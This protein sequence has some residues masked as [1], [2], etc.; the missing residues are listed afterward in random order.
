LECRWGYSDGGLYVGAIAGLSSPGD[1]NL[2]VDGVAKVLGEIRQGSTDYGSYGIQTESR[3]YAADYG[4]FIGGVHVGGAEDPG[5]DNLFVDGSIRIGSDAYGAVVEKVM[6]INFAHGVANQI[7]YLE[8]EG[9]Y[10][11]LDVEI[12]SGYSNQAAW[13]SLT[14]R[15]YIAL[16]DT[17]ANYNNQ[18]WYID[19]GGDIDDNF[20]IGGASWT[21]SVWRIP[22]E[23]LNSNGNRCIVRIHA[24]AYSPT[25]A[26][27]IR[28]ASLSAVTTGT[29][30]Q[31]NA[32][33]HLGNDR[34]VTIGNGLVASLRNSKGMVIKNGNA[35]DEILTLENDDVNQPYTSLTDNRT[36]GFF[37]KVY[38]AYGGLKIVGVAEDSSGA[39][40]TMELQGY[41]GQART[42]LDISTWG[43][44]NFYVTELSGNAQANVTANGICFTWN[45]RRGGTSRTIMAIDE[46]GDFRF[47]LSHAAMDDYEDGLVAR[48][49]AQVQA[50][51]YD[52]VLTYDVDALKD[53]GLISGDERGYFMSLKK[54]TALSLGAHAQSWYERSSIKERLAAVEQAAESL[55]NEN[56]LLRGRMQLLEAA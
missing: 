55:R 50:G 20:A 10:G 24:F 52:N 56:D 33:P 42:D 22:I 46:D 34:G 32:R 29:L 2:V 48:D 15:F 53:I 54:F 4:V 5:T 16:K 11:R 12:T 35:D 27:Y 18:G 45:I 14:K 13:G 6:Q 31:T 26:E 44:M 28:D 7:S 25:Y 47:D 21:G 38:N 41:G 23:H 8:F 9:F 43:L 3:I 36:F 30:T 51:A 37:K 1:N 40:V 17:G 49:L 19:V 39:P